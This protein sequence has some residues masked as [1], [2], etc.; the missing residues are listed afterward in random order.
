MSVGFPIMEPSGFKMRH[1]QETAIEQALKWLY[2]DN[3][4]SGIIQLATGCG[5]TPM[6]GELIR[7]VI[8]RGLGSRMLFLAH[9]DEL[10][11]QA[12][13][14][15]N[16]SGLAAGREQGSQKAD[17]MFPAQVVVS[18]VQT[19]SR[20]YP[21][22]DPEE[23]D[24][25]VQ[26]EC[27][28]GAG[29]TF[30]S[31]YDHFSGAKLLGI[32]AT[33]DRADRKKLDH[34]TEVIYRYSLWD[35]IHDDQGPFLTPIKLVR[36]NVGAD[37]RR[38]R[39]IGKKGD[40]NQGDLAEAIQPFIEI[41]ANAIVKEIEH[42]KTMVFMPCVN[43]ATAMAGALKQLG[44]S[45]D[46][47]SGDRPDRKEIVREYKRGS[48]QVIVNCDMLGEGFDD[49]G[50]EVVVLKPTRSRIAFAQ[51]VGRCTR[52]FEGKEFARVIDFNHTTD[53]ELIGPGSL[54]D[55]P[56]ST[57]KEVEKIVREE[58]EVN[59]WEAVE[60]AKEEV[61][62]REEMQVQV[63]QLELQYRRVEVDPFV[64]AKN[65][66]LRVSMRTFGERAT[67]MQV[68]ALKKFRVDSPESLSKE[69]ASRLLGSLIERS[70]A[71][72]AT[73]RQVN[74]LI[75]KGVNPHT[76]RNMSRDEAGQAIDRLHQ[77]WQ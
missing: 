21:E 26:D 28:R 59:L 42:R 38:C 10:I 32:T 35:A 73:I 41:F 2:E 19:M 76:A 72:L 36:I 9:R 8:A 56:D 44:V 74:Y 16:A 43:S 49:P 51:M 12:I 65:L 37:L 15:L 13:D 70:K 67:P 14:V 29:K 55:L 31:I 23:F 45:A 62:K 20:R 24:L 30:R 25:I 4:P 22:W 17:S 77:Q 57:A 71:G 18:T 53:L 5:K 47:V 27:H 39:T 33:I 48:F 46:W 6:V 3:H 63:A 69:Q 7:R 64:M 40:F 60:R 11:T 50:T 34:F 66:G 54:A 75:H 1:Y 52:L 61:R 68:A 58:K